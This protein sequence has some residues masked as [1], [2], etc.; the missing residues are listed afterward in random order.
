MYSNLKINRTIEFFLY[1]LGVVLAGYAFLGKGFAYLGY[2]PVFIGEITLALG[3]FTLVFTFAFSS[4]TEK[5]TEGIF[6]LPI[7]RLLLV[8]LAFGSVHIMIGFFYHGMNAL[9]DGVLF[10]YSI[11]A[12]LVSSFLFYS[13][14]DPLFIRK[15]KGLIVAFLVWIPVGYI[16]ARNFGEYIPKNIYGGV[17]IIVVKGEDFA[18]HLVGIIIFIFLGLHLHS[19]RGKDSNF[20]V[21]KLSLYVIWA[22]GFVFVICEKRAGFVV[23]IL[24]FLITLFF[25]PMLI[26]RRFMI[27]V[28]TV[29]LT[30]L[31]VVF[32]EP[33]VEL[34]NG[35]K[36]SYRQI[37]SNIESI[38]NKEESKVP[39]SL[40]QN[41]RWR[42]QEESEVPNSL[43]Q[44]AKWRLQ[45][46]RKVVKYTVLG[47]YFWT[48]K[49]MGFNLTDDDIPGHE[50]K[51]LRSPHNVSITFL[52]RTGVPGLAIWLT[53]QVWFGLYMLS[54]YF[55]AMK[56]QN[57]ILSKI[58]IWII[59]Y[60]LAFLVNA[61]F[62]VYLEGPPGGIWFWS[63]FGFGIY[64]GMLSR[65]KTLRIDALNKHNAAL[66]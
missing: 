19:S 40:S 33:N 8:F 28:P 37:K 60:W 48:G 7:M 26:L 27:F 30:M 1:F 46:W 20:S 5:I 32:A 39:N 31:I 66:K 56:N 63:L 61:S 58:N 53:L 38:I 55:Q 49:G 47:D 45:W 2:F 57:E 3:L 18:V 43:S 13:K 25:R 4:R 29:V 12:I 34:K 22:L 44:N 51:L 21:G 35:R 17:P 65:K 36:I 52:A 64:V 24:A 16:L 11:F 15:Y 14:L 6:C 41:A 9:R 23:M 50:D 62:E 42:L 10:T 59:A 54:S